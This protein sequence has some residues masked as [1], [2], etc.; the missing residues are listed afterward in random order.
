MLAGNEHG[1]TAPRHNDRAVSASARRTLSGSMDAADSGGAERGALR[2]GQREGGEGILSHLSHVAQQASAAVA[3]LTSDTD[4]G[5]HSPVASSQGGGAGGNRL[6]T[7]QR[8]PADLKPVLSTA[9]IRLI[10]KQLPRRCVGAAWKCVFHTHADG[11]SLPTLYRKAAPFA[12]CVLVVVSKSGHTMAAFTCRPWRTQRHF[13]GTGETMLFELQPEQQ[14][15]KW[16]QH[17]KLFQ[18]AKPQALALG[19]GG[20]G[21]ALYLSDTLQKGTSAASATFG[22]PGSLL[23]DEQC[24]IIC[25]ELW[26]LV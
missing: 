22:N 24:E 2:N 15:H 13:F 12:D 16:T 19:G 5:G 1:A 18:L 11:Y 14:V 25:V 21:F 3:A 20:D 7:L 10:H 6:P 9:S 17:N 23:G 4:G 26:A 8:Y